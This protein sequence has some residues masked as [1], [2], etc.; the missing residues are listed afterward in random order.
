MTSLNA[1]IVLGAAVWENGP[2]PTLLRRAARAAEL[3]HNSEVSHIIGTGA[4]GKHP[5]SEASV[6]AELLRK[7]GV[8]D[9]AILME[10]Q[11][12]NTGQN[13]ANALPLLR[14]LYITDVTLVTDLYHQ[15]RARLIARRAGLKAQSASPPLKGARAKTFLKGALREIPA[16]LAVL[17]RLR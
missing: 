8:P 7:A 6:I 11:S 5:P 15:P 13:I 10:D 12:H 17:L 2:S 16:T 3:Y 4:I 14:E 1:A 9:S